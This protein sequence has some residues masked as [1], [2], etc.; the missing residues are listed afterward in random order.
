[1]ICSI[2]ADPHLIGVLQMFID[3]YCTATAIWGT[4]LE[5]FQV[6]SWQSRAPSSVQQDDG[7]QICIVYCAAT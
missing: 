6:F 3:Y 1:M 4:H 7:H 2:R 5:V